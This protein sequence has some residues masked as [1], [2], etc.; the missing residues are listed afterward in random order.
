M[1][2]ESNASL[3]STPIDRPRTPAIF[4]D[5]DGTLNVEVDH[6]CR[7]EDVILVPGAA[8][9][10]FS[11]NEKNIPV[12]V[13]TNQ[14]G[15]GRGIF[16]WSDYQA[17]MEKIR[18]L[19]ACSGAHIDD[20]YVCPFHQDALDEY[21]HKDHP[22]RKPNPGMILS[23]AAKWNIDLERSWMIGDKEIDMGAGRNAGCR[24]ALVLTGYGKNINPELADIV[25]DDLA[26]AIEKIIAI[27]FH[28]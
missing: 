9:A 25:A 3:H 11:L 6:L 26:Q 12:I 18:E 7:P 16:G 5:R 13:I 21:R 17:V 10:I 28:F 27:G 24:T 1:N 23:A 22:D 14:S 20:A 19:L 2:R 15:I 4:L 8:K